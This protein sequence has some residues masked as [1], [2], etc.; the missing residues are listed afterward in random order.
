MT[1]QMHRKVEV[2]HKK[3][4]DDARTEAGGTDAKVR[5]RRKCSAVLQRTADFSLTFRRNGRREPGRQFGAFSVHTFLPPHSRPR[6]VP[7]R[8][9]PLERSPLCAR[10][11]SLFSR[12]AC[13]LRI[14]GPPP[15][16]LRP[17]PAPR[18]PP[19]SPVCSTASRVFAAPPLPASLCLPSAQSR[20]PKNARF[21][22][23]F[24][25]LPPSD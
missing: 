16:P 22:A 3:I 13:F 23:H 18:R 15:P 7:A 1:K 6:C 9:L 8:A 12:A 14:A 21:S 25:S 10:S 17:P 2:A 4:Q 11:V 19:P 5:V 24:P 20:A